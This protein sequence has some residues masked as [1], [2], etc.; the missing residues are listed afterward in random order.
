VTFD[1]HGMGDF[2]F[3]H[4]AICSLDCA[5]DWLLTL[6]CFLH[7]DLYL[8]YFDDW[9]DPDSILSVI[10]VLHFEVGKAIQN[11]R[12]YQSLLD[13]GTFFLK[14]VYAPPTTL[15]LYGHLEPLPL[16]ELDD[17]NWLLPDMDTSESYRTKMACDFRQVMKA[18]MERKFG[19]VHWFIQFMYLL[20]FLLLD[21]AMCARWP[22]FTFCATMCKF[23]K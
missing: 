18:T 6:L 22:C 11:G 10:Y 23:V 5:G 17:P 4:C 12:S 1:I 3:M 20:I 13:N 15:E 2:I 21:P 19:Q 16:P 9:V 7:A 14:E 8:P